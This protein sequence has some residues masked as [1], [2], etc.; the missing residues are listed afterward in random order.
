MIFKL[1]LTNRENI[2]VFDLIQNSFHTVKGKKYKVVNGNL[3]KRCA[4]IYS[5]IFTI[6]SETKLRLI[7][8]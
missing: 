3:F 6:G 4:C 8:E 7:Q 5:G 1:N 2:G